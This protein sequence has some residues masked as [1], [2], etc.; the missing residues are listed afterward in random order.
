VGSSSP[1]E[2]LAHVVF[3]LSLQP[4]RTCRSPVLCGVVPDARASLIG[5]LRN[6]SRSAARGL[7]GRTRGGGCG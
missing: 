6:R 1:R 3:G 5:P 2:T 7:A 4:E